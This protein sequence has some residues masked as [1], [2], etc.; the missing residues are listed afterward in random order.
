MLVVPVMAVFA[1]AAA[2]IVR[3]SSWLILGFAIWFV[4]VEGLVGQLKWWLPFSAYLE[5]S[6]GDAFGLEIF[7]FWAVVAVAVALPAPG[8]RPPGRLIPGGAQRRRKI[9]TPGE[10]RV[11]RAH[12]RPQTLGITPGQH[13]MRY[14]GRR[15]LGAETPGHPRADRS[16]SRRPSSTNGT[17]ASS[18]SR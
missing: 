6:G 7:I 9:P 8:P 5:A 4:V 17:P 18:V 10:Q 1:A 12:C 2:A 3:R 15:Q 14:A 16:P 13:Q 11:T